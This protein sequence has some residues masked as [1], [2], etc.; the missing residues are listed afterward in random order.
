M[1]QRFCSDQAV[2]AYALER[3]ATAGHVMIRRLPSPYDAV[4]LLLIAYEFPPSPSPQS[5]RWFHLARGS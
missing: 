2:K 5:L 4:R 1:S 3:V